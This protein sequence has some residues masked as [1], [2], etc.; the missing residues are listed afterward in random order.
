[1]PVLKRESFSLFRVVYSFTLIHRP[2]GEARVCIDSD[3]GASDEVPTRCS[4]GRDAFEWA[5]SKAGSAP[6]DSTPAEEP[7]ASAPEEAPLVAETPSEEPASAE[8]PVQ[9]ATAEPS[10]LE[11]TSTD[12]APHSVEATAIE[13]SQT[14]APGACAG[15][16][17]ADTAGAAGSAE[18]AAPDAE[19]G[20]SESEDGSSAGEWVTPDNVHRFGLAVRPAEKEVRVTCATADYSV[21]NVL[22][23]MGIT[24]L[25]FDGY[26]VRTV[27]LWGLI[28]RA[29][30]HFHRDS[31][32]VFCPKC[33]N[34][35]VVRV[36]IVVG[37]DGQPTVLNNGRPL[38]RKGSVYSVP[39]PQGGRGWKPV[40]AEDELLMGG[41]DRE[42][43]HNQKMAEK[44]RMAKDP[45]NEDN[46]AR[47]WHQRG[48][49][50]TGK[51]VSMDRPRVQAGYGRRNPNANNFKFRGGGRKAK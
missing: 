4:E 27:K 29:C 6:A 2:L 31:Q 43:R 39:K 42:L 32:K 44:E 48:H 22:L 36:P 47:A 46:G 24:P 19:A 28:C 12:A 21:Q 14:D 41:R 40:F 17:A 9:P 23:Q 45:F 1:M 3:S 49:T 35:T 38:R 16:A 15:M 13:A 25:T 50:S 20:G 26:A 11:T 5:P 7:Q 34:D 10:P 30:F 8:S 33:G 51:Q 18:V 37:E